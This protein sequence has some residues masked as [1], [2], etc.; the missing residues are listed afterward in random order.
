MSSVIDILKSTYCFCEEDIA[1][2][3][4]GKNF[5]TFYHDGKRVLCPEAFHDFSLS[6]FGVSPQYI[7]SLWNLEYSPS[8]PSFPFLPDSTF[9]PPSTSKDEKP[10]LELSLSPA[11][12][13]DSEP[14]KPTFS[15]DL[16]CAINFAEQYP[17]KIKPLAAVAYLVAEEGLSLDNAASFL[18]HLGYTT[19]SPAAVRFKINKQNCKSIDEFYTSLAC[20][21]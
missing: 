5:F 16:S 6:V 11:Q 7:A 9:L 17:S 4:F 21:D 19:M 12:V 1:C 18:D 14:L 2:L 20:S 3:K 8:V 10:S 15:G 13:Y